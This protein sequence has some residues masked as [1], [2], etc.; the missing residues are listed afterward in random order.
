MKD[1]G[2]PLLARMETEQGL[3]EIDCE[4]ERVFPERGASSRKIDVEFDIMGWEVV[5]TDTGDGDKGGGL[6]RGLLG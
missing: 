6:L 4:F 1:D 5:R 2:E 3:K